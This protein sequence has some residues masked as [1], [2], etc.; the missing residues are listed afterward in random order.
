MVA[1]FNNDMAFLSITRGLKGSFLC[2]LTGEDLVLTAIKEPGCE[3]FLF[4]ILN[5]LL[6]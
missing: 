5:L 2:F 3:G 4:K 1:G 6:I